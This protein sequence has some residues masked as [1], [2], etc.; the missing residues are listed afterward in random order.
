MKTL[1]IDMSP[2][3]ASSSVET[4][5]PPLQST[6]TDVCVTTRYA[7][8]AMSLERAWTL[9]AFHSARVPHNHLSAWIVCTGVATSDERQVIRWPT[10]VATTIKAPSW[11]QP[12]F[13]LPPGLKLEDPGAILPVL[14]AYPWL[15]STLAIAQQRLTALL[16]ASEFILRSLQDPDGPSPFRHEEVILA[17]RTKSTPEQAAAALEQFDR[18]WWLDLPASSKR[19]LLVT[20]EFS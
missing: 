16:P 5:S 13:V 7:S 20:V 8:M 3:I 9:W 19:G 18:D 4:R 11:R 6:S 12:K 10:S 1:Q 17:V 14:E 2:T 15:Q